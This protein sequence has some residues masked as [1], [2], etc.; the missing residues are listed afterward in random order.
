VRVTSA[1]IMSLRCLRNS[2]TWIRPKIAPP[3]TVITPKICA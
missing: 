2:D 3:I 1:A